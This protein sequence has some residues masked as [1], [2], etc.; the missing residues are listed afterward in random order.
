[1]IQ[2]CRWYYIEVQCF[3][4]LPGTL[5]DQTCDKQLKFDPSKSSTFVDEGV[6]FN[7]SFVTGPGVHPASSGPGVD[8]PVES[9]TMKVR[10]GTD[11]VSVGG[12]TAANTDLD[13][14]T[15]QSARFS[16][17]PFSGFLGKPKAETRLHKV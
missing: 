5:C 12:L 10:T 17:D 16:E 13:L 1:M 8:P 9:D 15:S 4:F 7:L 3:F 14:I 11:T 2:S 6:E